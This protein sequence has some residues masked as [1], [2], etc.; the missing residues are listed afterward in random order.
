MCIQE[1]VSRVRISPSPPNSENPCNSMSYG[2]FS[3]KVVLLGCTTHH[4]SPSG[5]PFP[6]G[7]VAFRSHTPGL[8]PPPTVSPI[9]PPAVS[10][11]MLRPTSTVRQVMSM[12]LRGGVG[13]EAFKH[14]GITCI[15]I[16]KRRIDRKN[17]L[18]LIS[19]K[20][21]TLSQS[22]VEYSC[23]EGE[24]SLSAFGADLQDRPNS[25]P[26]PIWWRVPLFSR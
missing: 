4:V 2:G 16:G 19:V 18:A 23:R 22:V 7:A 6:Q 24:V 9:T 15:A 8:T 17:I 20:C 13:T 11:S 14:G 12:A 5:A 10:R 25:H 26:N 3:F 1:T 21:L